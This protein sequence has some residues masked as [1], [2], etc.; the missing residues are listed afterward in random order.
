MKITEEENELHIKKIPMICDKPIQTKKGIK[1][2][3]PLMQTSHM[4]L[5]N[6]FSGS[7]KTNLIMS[8]LKRTS[9]TKKGEAFSY[10]HMF[11]NIIFV[12]PSAHTIR[13][14]PLEHLSDDKKFEHLEEE[15]F[16][17]VYSLTENAVEDDI[18]TLLILDDVSSELRKS[19]PLTVQLNMLVKNR[20]Q[21][22]V[23]IWIVGHKITDF[24]PAL[25]CNA[26]LIFLFQ[27]KGKKEIET[28]HHEFLNMNIEEVRELL[29]Y[30]YKEKHTFLLIDMTLRNGG[31]IEFYKNFNKLNITNEDN[32][33]YSVNNI[34]AENKDKRKESKKSKEGPEKNQS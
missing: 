8:L 3:Y 28:I 14:N 13:D 19:K 5:I 27:P 24:E 17:K 10:R 18:H 6:G 1:V 11:D 20:R 33:K 29:E 22:N 25:R 30:V 21:R 9:K 31:N 16:E 4:Y 26:S 34:D 12:S 2:A 7:G 23:S 32:K 15:V